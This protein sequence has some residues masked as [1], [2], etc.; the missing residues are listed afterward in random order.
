MA[1][2]K[3]LSFITLP[4]SE[5]DP[6]M[7]RRIRTVARLEEQKVLLRNPSYIRKIRTFTKVDGIRQ[8]FESDQRVTPWWRKNADGS[9]LFSIRVGSKAIDFERGKAAIAVPSIDKL[10]EIIDTLIAATRAG[11]LDAQLAAASR[12]PP[13][14]RR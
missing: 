13:T 8:A 7:E 14:K 1:S 12:Q 3:S 6:K 11:E 9:Y 2:L 5:A 4:K 10:P